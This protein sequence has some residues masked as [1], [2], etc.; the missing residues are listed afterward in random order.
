MLLSSRVW[1]ATFAEGRSRTLSCNPAQVAVSCRVHKYLIVRSPYD[2]ELVTLLTVP[3]VCI[4]LGVPAFHKRETLSH[5]ARKSE[6]RV[7]L[8]MKGISQD[9]RAQVRCRSNF[10]CVEERREKMTDQT[11][12]T[13]QRSI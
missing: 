6:Q 11:K 12:K 1:L 7:D 5:T 13:N 4:T 10:R 9:F 2:N 3:N 8:P